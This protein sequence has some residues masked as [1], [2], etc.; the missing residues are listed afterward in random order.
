MPIRTCFDPALLPN[1]FGYRCLTRPTTLDAESRRDRIR[2]TFSPRC[3]LYCGRLLMQGAVASEQPVWRDRFVLRACAYRQRTESGSPDHCRF[4]RLSQ[5][6]LAHTICELLEWRRPEWEAEEPRVRRVVAEMQEHNS[7]RVCR[8]LR[9]HQA[10]GAHRFHCDSQSDPQ[11]SLHG[12]LADYQ[13]L[14]LQLIEDLAG[15]RLFQQ[16]YPALPSAGLRVPRRTTAVSGAPAAL[17]HR[18]C[19][20]ACCLQCRLENGAARRLDWVSDQ[21]RRANPPATSTTAAF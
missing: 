19:W 16:I 9:S 17:R 3:L 20:P 8:S 21:A 1:S 5:A 6:E 18:S 15:R 14:R 13:P 2:W 7:C 11:P 4:P 12:G 10:R